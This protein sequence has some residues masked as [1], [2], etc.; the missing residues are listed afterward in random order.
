MT[1]NEARKKITDQAVRWLGRKESDGSWWPII[2]VWNAYAKRTG[3][4]IMTKS[5]PWCAAYTSAVFIACGLS[6]I[7]PMEV[8]CGRMVVEAEKRGLWIEDD[9]YLP[10]PG[11]LILYDWQDNGKGDDKGDPDHVG[12]VIA[13]S[14]STFRIAEGNCNDA[15]TEMVRTR[16][17][18]YIRG[19]IVPDYNSVA[20]TDP[21]PEPEPEPEPTPIQEGIV[22]PTLRNGD[23]GLTVKAMQGILIA[24]GFRC[25]WYGSDG[26]FGPATEKA[27][28]EFQNKNGLAVDGICGHDTWVSLLG[29]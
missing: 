13:V 25:G 1:E 26:E 27:L 20:D 8:S 14:G 10:T 23:V 12:L 24:R 4:Y 28:R 15:V 29:V 21:E 7:T 19:F 11:D 2:E 3:K 5:D 22:I 16:N 9:G 17:Q 6:E 18:L